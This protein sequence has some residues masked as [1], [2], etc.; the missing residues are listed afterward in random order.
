MLNLLKQVFLLLPPHTRSKWLLQIPLTLVLG[1][2][3]F[4]T[5]Y[6]IFIAISALNGSESNS[7][8]PWSQAWLTTPPSTGLVLS[9]LGGMLALSFTIKNGLMFGMSYLRHSLAG[10]S[11]AIYAR[12]LLQRYLQSDYQFHLRHETAELIN[13]IRYTAE[14]SAEHGI[15]NIAAFLQE[16]LTILSLWGVLLATSLWLGLVLPIISVLFILIINRQ[17]GR[18]AN[19]QVEE[20]HTARKNVL[21][22]TQQL[23]GSFIEIKLGNQDKFFINDFECIQTPYIGAYGR[24]MAWTA[25]APMILEA[26]MAIVAGLT[27]IAI[28]LFSTASSDVLIPILGAYAYIL[29]RVLPASKQAMGYLT[30]LESIRFHL[31]RLLHHVHHLPVEYKCGELHQRLYL[32]QNLT[33]KDLSFTYSHQQKP[34]IQHVN[35]RIKVGESIGIVGA[36]GA[37]KSTLVM[38]IMGFLQSEQGSITVDG[39]SIYESLPAW[40][41]GIGYVS[42]HIYLLNTSVCKNI[43]LG[44]DDSKVDYDWLNKCIQMACLESVITSL[45]E[46]LNTVVGEDGLRLSGGQRQRIAIARALYRRPELLLLDEATSALDTVTERTVTD[47][48]QRLH[49]QITTVVIA[50]RLSTV[51]ECDRL[52]FLQDGRLI[53]IGNYDDLY[54]SNS[55]FR[56]LAGGY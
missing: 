46:G 29:F 25:G 38:S 36:S 30:R 18:Y 17:I 49:G 28:G 51:R 40:R 44:V 19:C 8:M 42:Q 53:D 9:A 47:A 43:A 3:E 54:N 26:L 11:S 37:G 33:L 4:L 55:E 45:P 22:H 13:N 41:Q 35:A 7:L 12:L 39:H 50:H 6:M 10:E 32:R 27:L 2:I 5:A 48:I 20:L 1:C 23:L 56:K 15:G 14:I 34:A 52:L 24:A 31:E 16:S 21:S